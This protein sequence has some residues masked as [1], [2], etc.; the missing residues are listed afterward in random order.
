MGV[1]HNHGQGM[2]DFMQ[3]N[4]Q[5]VSKNPEIHER[6]REDKKIKPLL[7]EKREIKKVQFEV[8]MTSNTE[9]TEKSETID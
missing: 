3:Q 7:E 9:M 8:S 6:S 5:M 1:D 2:I 4:Y